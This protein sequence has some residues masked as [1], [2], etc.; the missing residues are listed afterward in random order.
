MP[1]DASAVGHCQLTLD[2][3]SDARLNEPITAT[4]TQSTKDL[5]PA[6]G[7]WKFGIRDSDNDGSELNCSTT[8][9]SV[10]VTTAT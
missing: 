4:P 6:A 10:T 2:L 1:A 3:Y 7:N 9:L 8:G 5:V